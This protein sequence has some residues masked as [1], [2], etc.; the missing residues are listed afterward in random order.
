MLSLQ[1]LS[2]AVQEYAAIE[3]ELRELAA[4][5]KVLRDR[6]S[7][8]QTQILQTMKDNNLESRTM[9]QGAH[10]FY[11]GTR[12]QYSSLSFSY[13]ETAFEKMIPDKDNRDFLLEYLRDNREVKH[14]AELKIV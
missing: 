4:K 12:K 8:L 6:K 2:P 14:V 9:K 3:D 7:I 10:H 1:T 11:I 13:L 5:Q